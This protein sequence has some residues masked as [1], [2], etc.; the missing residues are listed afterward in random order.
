MGRSGSATEGRD[1][2]LGAW[3]TF[4]TTGLA[5]VGRF[6]S[7]RASAAGATAAL[8]VGCCDWVA[9][10]GAGVTATA[11]FACAGA[12]ALI[13]GRVACC[14]GAGAAISGVDAG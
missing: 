4:A 13:S 3:V 8:T 2:G 1:V 6:T 9:T 10:G 11:A 7:L 5:G 14:A 12:G